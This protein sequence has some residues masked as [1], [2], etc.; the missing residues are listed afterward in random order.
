MDSESVPSS[1]RAFETICALHDFGV[2]M[3][4][5]NLRASDPDAPDAVIEE[6]LRNWMGWEVSPRDLDTH[7]A[8]VQPTRFADRK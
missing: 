3:M 8:V 5:Q 4:R 1:I 6:R 7:L 2:D